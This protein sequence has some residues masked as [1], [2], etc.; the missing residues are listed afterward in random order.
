M[1]QVEEVISSIKQMNM[2]EVMDLVKSLEEEFGVSAAP[3]VATQQVSPQVIE[4][5]NNVEAVD[6]EVKMT[7]FGEKKIEVIKVVRTLLA[8][9]LKESKDLV[10]ASP[11]VVKKDLTREEA[12]EIKT[13]L[14]AAG[15]TVVIS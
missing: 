2:S 8:L 6:L 15:A 14:E 9:G 5:I 13:A 11:V 10:E 1:S 3:Q 7:D 4:E 12:E